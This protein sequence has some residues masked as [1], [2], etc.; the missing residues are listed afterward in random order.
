M[1]ATH[2]VARGLYELLGFSAEGTL[3]EK[4]FLNGQFVDVVL[5]ALLARDYDG[6]ALRRALFRRA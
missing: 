6:D 5:F 4:R 1:L 2:T 3:R